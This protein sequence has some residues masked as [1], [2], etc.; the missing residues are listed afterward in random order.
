MKYRILRK[1]RGNIFKVQEQRYTGDYDGMYLKWFDC[2]RRHKKIF[3]FFGIKIPYT[4]Y[5][6][7]IFPKKEKAQEFLDKLVYLDSIAPKDKVIVET[8]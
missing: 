6:K 4:R 7:A 5:P 2:Y 8:P 1:G 3:N